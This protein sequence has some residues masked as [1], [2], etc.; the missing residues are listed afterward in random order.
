MKGF[1][2]EAYSDQQIRDF[3]AARL[4]DYVIY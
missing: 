1:N 2:H 4:G 3:L